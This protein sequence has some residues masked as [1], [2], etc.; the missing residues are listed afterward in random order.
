MVVKKGATWI[1]LR[2]VYIAA[3]WPWKKLGWLGA[4]LASVAGADVA[5]ARAAALALVLRRAAPFA[6]RGRLMCTCHVLLWAWWPSMMMLYMLLCIHV[7]VR[8]ASLV[9]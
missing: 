9:C 5:V 2:Y 1:P 6:P 4:L 3:L 7:L 8:V